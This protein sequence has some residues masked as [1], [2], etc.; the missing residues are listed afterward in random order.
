MKYCHGILS[1]TNFRCLQLGPSC[2]KKVILPWFKRTSLPSAQI[3]PSG[4]HN[5]RLKSLV[6]QKPHLQQPFGGPTGNWDVA[7]DY[8][9]VVTAWTQSY[10]LSSQAVLRQ[11]CCSWYRHKDVQCSQLEKRFVT[12]SENEVNNHA[13]I[14]KR[15][16]VNLLTRLN[17]WCCCV[18]WNSPCSRQCYA[19]L[20]VGHRTLQRPQKL[21]YWQGLFQSYLAR[22]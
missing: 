16:Q 5:T 6:V 12:I 20:R 22:P 18:Y 4:N 13:Y 15:S 8:V 10:V 14:G 2:W 3:V 11:S 9:S 1:S 7:L 21:T 17:F 19:E